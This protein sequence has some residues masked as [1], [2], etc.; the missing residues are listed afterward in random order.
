MA[1][2]ID[3]AAAG[4]AIARSVRDGS[5]RIDGAET[6]FSMELYEEQSA[7]SREELDA[8]LQGFDVR[9]CLPVLN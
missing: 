3:G 5:S 6:D 8:R 1:M 4:G 7:M 9:T 2:K